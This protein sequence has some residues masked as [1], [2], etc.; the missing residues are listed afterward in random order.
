MG[1]SVNRRN[2]FH[3]HE[4]MCLSPLKVLFRFWVLDRKK[5]KNDTGNRT[6]M[7]TKIPY[8]KSKS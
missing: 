3:I 7:S 1:N 5:V 2:R 6:T 4:V 8:R